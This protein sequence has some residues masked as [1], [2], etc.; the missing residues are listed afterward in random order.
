M[1]P[2]RRKGSGRAAAAAAQQQW[3]VG[4]LVLAKMRGFPAWPAM[5]SEPEKWGFPAQ[6]KKL[7]VYFY[8]TKQ[9]A[10]CNYADIEAF[11]EE[12]KKS[13]LLKRQGKGA[14]FVRAVDEIIDIYETSKK[15]K[16]EGNSLGDEG[17]R[18][19][20][21]LRCV[22]TS[23]I[24]S[25]FKNSTESGSHLATN[26]NFE[27]L[28]DMRETNN[29]VGSEEVSATSTADDLQ[30]N[31]VTD[32]PIQIVSILDQLRQDPLTTNNT[33]RKKRL[34]DA[35]QHRSLK[36]R[37]RSSLADS[38][39]IH[40]P[41]SVYDSDLS[42]ALTPDLVQ[43]ANTESK[44]KNDMDVPCTASSYSGSEVGAEGAANGYEANEP[45]GGILESTCHQ[46]VSTNGYLNNEERL[47]GKVKSPKECVVVKMTRKREDIAAEFS[48]L[49]K[50]DFLF[51]STPNSLNEIKKE[52]H[53]ADGDEHL[54]LVKRARVRMGK[55][56]IEEAQH[57][58]SVC[59]DEKTETSSM[60][61][62]C[63]KNHMLFSLENNS[64]PLNSNSLTAKEDVS[65][66]LVN[67]CSP[68]QGK[69]IIFW[70]AKKYQLNGSMLDVEAALPPSKRLHRALEAMSANANESTDDRRESPRAMEA[71]A[72]MD[73]PNISSLHLSSDTKVGSPM[74]LQNVHSSNGI[75][76]LQNLDKPSLSSSEV[77]PR[78]FHTESIR[79][80]HNHN[81]NEDVGDAAACNGCIVP[82]D[83]VATTQM[84]CEQPCS[85]MFV[86]EENVA[87]SRGIPN[88]EFTFLDK[89]NKKLMEDKDDIHN[90][91]KDNANRNVSAEP[92]LHKE[93]GFSNA[94]ESVHSFPP[95]EAVQTV[96]AAD[97]VSV[98]STASGATMCSSFQSD[99]DSHTGNMQGA[100]RE[101]Q[102]RDTPYGRSISP[103]LT[104]MK[105]L[106]A[107][108]Q[109]KR[110]LSHSTSFSHNYFDSK[111]FPDAI[112]SPSQVHKGDFS[113]NGSSP[114]SSGNHTS[115]IDD[116]IHAIQN[117]NTSPQIGLQLKGTNRYNHAEANAARRTFEALLCTLS[118][119]KDSI[120]RATRLAMDC[121]KYGMAGEVLEL[122]LQYLER[123]QSL[124][125]RVDLFFLV[126][127]ITQCSRNQKGGLGDMYPALVQSMLPRLLSAAAPRGNAA[128][129]NRRQCLK[130]LRLWL[131]RKTLPESIVRHHM[132]ELDCSNELSFSS[133]SSRRPSR[134]ERA[135]NDPLREMEGMLVDEYG[136]NTN[137]QLPYLLSTNVLEDEEGNGSDEKSFEAV[138]PERGAQIDHEK[139]T[140]QIST[141]KNRH[142]LEDVDVELEMEDV[143]PPCEVNSA[144]PGAGAD[145]VHSHHQ[146]DQQF[147][148]PFAPPLPQ[149]RPPSPP[150]LPS[151]PPPLVSPCSTAHA[152]PQWQSGSHASDLHP[153]RNIPNLQNQ[154]SHFFNQ[155]PA[156]E[157][158]GL[159][160]SKPATYYGPNYGCIPSQM[161]PPTPASY[162]TASSHPSMHSHSNMQSLVNTPLTD[163]PYQLQPPPPTVSNHFSYVQNEPQQRAQPW[164]K[165][166]FP[167]RYQYGHESHR[168]NFHC[169]QGTRRHFQNE[170][171]PRSSFSS[172]HQ[173]GPSPYEKMEASPASLPHYGRP[174]EPPPMPCNGWSL[175]PR[176][177]NYIKPT[178]RPPVDAPIPDVGGGYWRPR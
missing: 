66:S 151:S 44:C 56:V 139:G 30:K 35:S 95:E 42:G 135:I 126:D 154:Q 178:S 119:T 159:M 176:M 93:D 10:F 144:C 177:P 57:G 29:G 47:Y 147:P 145:P 106:I 164:G 79:N 83:K 61:N 36:R 46:E 168:G 15:Q 100:S 116:R 86:E 146:V 5:I 13:L 115:T 91:S 51:S 167:E 12:K 14:D 4:D 20:E 138:T 34:R 78:D 43:N 11:T 121:G 109:A 28:C 122:L 41:T 25:S 101:T 33:S 45:N 160:P 155:Q 7:F 120:G 67:D 140:T 80:L 49:N 128:L 98:A 161:P 59:V 114:N 60:V 76:P 24:S 32:A 69:D 103:E 153:S 64:C 17:E 90:I 70:K 108:A 52:I 77:K 127:S 68:P 124:H 96:S 150:P 102:L 132:R 99:E 97:M 39:K 1:G 143:S 38:S 94:A 110:T 157:N 75:E 131:E 134:M 148:L 118:R 165:C 40:E 113:R 6:R 89:A 82:E 170:M 152:V 71:N 16:V 174:P 53:K 84:K 112:M 19:A 55:S 31:L 149:D 141:E 3:K 156:N 133:G 48:V 87:S 169:D 22:G 72:L 73:S 54:P 173:H 27:A 107:A 21:D 129:E 2:C 18:S 81:R 62:D 9:I 171:T 92:I 88:K 166:S 123:E 105:E 130:V 85:S 65:S 63:D 136:S 74:R 23:S 58:E 8:G 163:A 158:T 142:V 104:P 26:N 175:P 111:A 125:K 172:V 137:F 50:E 37:S 162:G 117:G